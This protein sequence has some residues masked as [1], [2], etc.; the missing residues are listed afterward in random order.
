M[1][2]KKTIDN[3]ALIRMITDK[4]PQNEIMAGFG[5]KTSTQLKVAYANALMETGQAPALES[6][7]GKKARG[8][9]PTVAIGKRGSIVISK[10]LVDHLGFKEGDT[11]EVRKSAAG[12]SLKKKDD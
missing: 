2:P 3:E 12:L 6:G 5:F 10:N 9:D 11:F 4:V 7:R 1:P 8:V